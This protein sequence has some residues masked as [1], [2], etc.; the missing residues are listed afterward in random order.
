MTSHNTHDIVSI[1]SIVGPQL[2]DQILAELQ[3]A[4]PPLNPT[5]YDTHEQIMY[6]AGQRSVVEWIANRLTK[7]N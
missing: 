7:E 5:P 6:R 4:H 2:N 3:Q 1:E